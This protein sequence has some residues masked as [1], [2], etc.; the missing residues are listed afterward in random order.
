MTRPQQ[1]TPL[2][3]ILAIGARSDPQLTSLGVATVVGLGHDGSLNVEY[4]D[5]LQLG[6]P[7]LDS[8]NAPRIGDSVAL[9]EV[10]GAFIILGRYGG[11]GAE[12]N[13]EILPTTSHTKIEP[14]YLRA[15][16]DEVLSDGDLPAQGYNEAA[17]VIMAG[18]WF[19]EDDIMLFT[20][21]VVATSMLMYLSR[22]VDD[23]GAES[24][25]LMLY[26][27][28]ALAPE[29]APGFLTSPE[30]QYGPS[31]QPGEG[32]WWVLPSEWVAA[33]SRGEARGVGITAH[34]M[35]DYL[36]MDESSGT[37]AIRK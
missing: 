28:R 18:A 29:D 30:P 20:G 2:S 23:G 37:I 9:L 24:V 32:T 1:R 5:S 12:V 4:N 34:E 36:V 8:Y 3:D 31:L 15:W 22:S 33:L 11:P 14:Y 19:Y 16:N 27:H 17:G 6:I 26:L 25:N 10:S 21:G 35:E 13:G 7:R